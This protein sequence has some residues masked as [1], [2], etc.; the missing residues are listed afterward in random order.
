MRNLFLCCTLALL[1]FAGWLIL[2]TPAVEGSTITVTTIADTIASD[3]QCSLREA[4][5]AAN[6][7]SVFNGCPAGSGAD[8]ITFD[9][10]LST[11]SIF[12][13]TLAGS[14][15][16]NAMTGDLDIIGSAINTLTITGAGLDNTIIDGNGTDRVFDIRPGA[17]ATISGVT[18]RNGNP[19]AGN[20]GGGIGLGLTSRLTLNSSRVFT[21]TAA[22]G[23]GAHVLGGL[24]LNDSTIEANYGGGVHNNAGLLD[25]NNAQ[26]IS[27]THGYG[28]TNEAKGF[29][30]FDGGTV[31][32][33]QGG[34]ILSDSS[35]ATLS[36]LN[37]IYNTGGGIHNKAL[38]AQSPSKLTVTSS[39]IMSNT[40]ASGGGLLNNGPGA[41]ATIENTRISFNTASPANGGGIKNG[42]TI[43]MKNSVL[44][45]N[46]A[47][48]GGG[49]DNGGFS[50]DL[51]NVTISGNTVNDNGGGL[52][53]R[54]SASLINV[55]FDGNSA[56][57]A[58]TGGNIYVD[59]DS[60]S[61][62]MRNSIIA[63]PGPG[64]NCVNNMGVLTSL[65]HNL[66]STDTCGLMATG[67]IT[68]TIPLLGPLQDNGGPTFTHAL[69]P[70]SPAIDQGDD[71]NCPIN[72]QRGI[73]R[74]QGAGCDIGAFEFAATADLSI[75]KQR[76]GTGDILSGES[77]TYTITITNGGPTT[78][79][80]A[81]VVDTWSPVSAVVA[82]SAPNCAVNL[83]DGTATCTVTNLG[84][85][86]ATVPAPH[87]VLTTA[88]SFSGE[89]SN[90]ARVSPND[91][92]IDPTPG[93]DESDLI[94]VNVITPYGVNLSPN[95]ALSDQAG[96]TVTYTL[97][98]TNTGTAADTFDLTKSGQAWPTTLSTSSIA[99][100]ASASS[101]FTVTVSIPAGAVG[102][103]NDSV[104]ITATSQGDG[105]KSDS[106]NLSTS[107]TPVYGVNL[108]PDDALSGLA[109][110]TVTYTLQIT[111]MGTVAD[112]FDLN[113][114][115]N[116]W[117]T[118]LSTSSISLAAGAST[119]FNAWVTIPGSAAANDDDSVSVI[120][121][122]QGDN[123]KSDTAVLTTTSQSQNNI[124]PRVFL[125]FV[126]GS[127]TTANP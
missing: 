61:L 32:G 49:I 24:T 85:E 92:I 41:D 98:I 84:L 99:L 38:T 76:V 37:I 93:N 106:A 83:A 120:A 7:D 79:I 44:D 127:V 71:S 16:D 60:A 62:S 17:R 112:T 31:S 115:G 59:G 64:G 56:D 104:S 47:L 11:P 12:V 88:T 111:N 19:G 116:S 23:G 15:E 40:A 35:T 36:N 81:T 73:S 117:L 95:D 107:V 14:G 123:L 57:A 105:T 65:G 109:G 6:T 102:K 69:L 28:I 18:I 125:P 121:T 21:N 90:F 22:S 26:I 13:L 3:D 72:D 9:P 39:S 51:T 89:L 50:L 91:G 1:L 103:D 55:T 27:N 42:G 82:V 78:P 86:S 63:N 66:E 33:N 10:A 97:F 34:G 52:H 30:L 20:D 126:Q 75:S 29:L 87:L 8:T 96:K 53:N 5:V 67:D 74:P 122:S 124:I 25:F 43:D 58:D 45:H 110:K 94:F 4:I 113:V 2:L 70:G 80:T 68:D 48:S 46:Q 119:T 100:A 54:T 77:I 101:S 118:S 108:S 114:S